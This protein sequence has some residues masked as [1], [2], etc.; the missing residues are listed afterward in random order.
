MDELNII[1]NIFN[2]GIYYSEVIF[3]KS[4]ERKWIYIKNTNLIV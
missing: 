3:Q 2:K 4:K 1:E